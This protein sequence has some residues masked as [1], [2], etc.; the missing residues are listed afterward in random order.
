MI[1][2]S[3]VT[4]ASEED[5]AVEPGGD[6]VGLGV[7]GVRRDAYRYAA[8]SR[9]ESKL[10]RVGIDGRSWLDRPGLEDERDPAARPAPR[11]PPIPRAAGPSDTLATSS[12]RSRSA[13]TGTAVD[14][15]GEQPF[16]GMSAGAWKS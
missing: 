8:G 14:V 15:H 13:R 11:A 2:T 12:V 6:G 7:L 4:S 5:G 10:T 16:T 9:S 1:H 3:S